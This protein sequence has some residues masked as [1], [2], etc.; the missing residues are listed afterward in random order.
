MWKETLN[1]TYRTRSKDTKQTYSLDTHHLSG[2][3]TAERLH[4]P[5]VKR[6]K[7]KFVPMHRK[8]IPNRLR[9]MRCAGWRVGHGVRASRC[10]THARVHNSSTVSTNS[11]SIVS[12]CTSWVRWTWRHHLLG[13]R[14]RGPLRTRRSGPRSQPLLLLLQWRF[15]F[16]TI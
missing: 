12:V 14:F 10:E 16:I 4:A 5:S 2:S 13:R 9:I 8:T 1:L 7:W 11:R 15:N 3:P 6:L